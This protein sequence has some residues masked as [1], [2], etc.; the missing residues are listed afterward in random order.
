MLS[1]AILITGCATTHPGTIGTTAAGSASLPLKVSAETVDNDY[2]SPFHLIEVTFENTS[3]NWV[4]IHRS[5]VLLGNPAESK[6]SV[7]L[8][9]DL[10]DWAQAKQLQL[11]KD[12]HN[13]KLLQAGIAT[14]GAVAISSNDQG[15]ANTGAIALVGTSAWAVSDVIRQGYQK[16]EQ[17]E[18]VPDNH[19]YQSFSVPGKMFLRKWILINKPS[20]I[21]IK[22]LA[23]EVETVEGEKA[24]YEIAL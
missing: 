8:G 5:E 15:I 9:R 6:L 10:R 18:K 2:K 14:A 1:L 13:R 4:K 7:V 22:K 12:E 19:L 21:L 23:L 3:E 11:L 20:H 24:Y 16:A 17:S